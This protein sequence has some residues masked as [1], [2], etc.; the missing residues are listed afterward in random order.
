[1]KPLRDFRSQLDS[2]LGGSGEQQRRSAPLMNLVIQPPDDL[3][4]DALSMLIKKEERP[5]EKQL[6]VAPPAEK[7]V[8]GK[9]IPQI[10]G[11]CIIP[12]ALLFSFL[13]IEIL[14]LR[15]RWCNFQDRSST[16]AAAPSASS[17]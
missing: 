2:L 3:D 4:A 5:S 9:L 13:S 1:L 10:A 14:I 6:D 11:V 16:L 7:T 15:T 8:W 17:S 12:V